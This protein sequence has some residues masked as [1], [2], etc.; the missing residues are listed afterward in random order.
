MFVI[1]NYYNYNL[2]HL[3]TYKHQDNHITNFVKFED[4]D[5]NYKRYSAYLKI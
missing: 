4:I 5:D 1:S 2:F 3:K